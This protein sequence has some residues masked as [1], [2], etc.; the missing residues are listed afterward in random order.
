[1]ARGNFPSLLELECLK[2]GAA[3]RY[4]MI[5]KKISFIF[6]LNKD[7]QSETTLF[8]CFFRL[9]ILCRRLCLW[10]PQ[11]DHCF[12][13]LPMASWD[14]FNQNS[15]HV[16]EFQMYKFAKFVYYV[17]FLNFPI[18]HY[19][20]RG[21]CR[22]SRGTWKKCA[23]RASVLFEKAPDSAKDPRSGLQL[24]DLCRRAFGLCLQ[25]LFSIQACHR[26]T[27]TCWQPGGDSLRSKWA[28]KQR[29]S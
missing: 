15:K 20:F 14:I 3:S 13:F 10:S 2:S 8:L 21:K 9:G 28:K 27:A 17:L 1:M 7:L 25:V 6:Y 29:N 22:T 16:F 26:A 19:W 23:Q 11:G 12:G 4:L 5:I 18:K 24:H